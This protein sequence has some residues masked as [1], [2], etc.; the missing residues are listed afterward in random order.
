LHVRELAGRS[1]LWLGAWAYGDGSSLQEAADD[2]VERL[3]QQARGLQAGALSAPAELSPPDRLWLEFLW[4]IGE[5]SARGED[6][7][8]RVLALDG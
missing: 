8:A 2:L 5:M 7:R 3:L 6:V 1:R 4:E